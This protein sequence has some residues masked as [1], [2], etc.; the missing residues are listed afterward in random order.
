MI[1]MHFVLGLVVFAALWATGH[2]ILGVVLA[3]VVTVV[4]YP[5]LLLMSPG[6][7]T[8]PAVAREVVHQTDQPQF[9]E[10]GANKV[11]AVAFAN[12]TT[13]APDPL[14]GPGVLALASDGS[15]SFTRKGKS[16]E[17]GR[18]LAG[19]GGGTPQ[20]PGPVDGY[21]WLDTDY[22]WTFVGVSGRDVLAVL[23]W[24][25]RHHAGSRR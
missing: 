9:Q 20:E 10:R 5:F 12:F 22:C 6:R 15:W 25:E 7:H 1:Y 3:L 17:G 19:W 18:A 11:K 23:A 4:S 21:L 14:W 8:S 2:P 13:T 16:L 24:L